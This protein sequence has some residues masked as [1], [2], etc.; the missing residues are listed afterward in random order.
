[1]IQNEVAEKIFVG[2]VHDLFDVPIMGNT[3]RPHYVERMF[4]IALGE[5]FRL[6]SGWA[7]WDIEHVT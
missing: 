3:Y 2:I 7:S 5:E 1:M 6:V 4:K